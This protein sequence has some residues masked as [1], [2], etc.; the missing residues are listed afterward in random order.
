MPRTRRGTPAQQAVVRSAGAPL[1]AARAGLFT[2]VSL[3]L[4]VA[5]HHLLTG[6]AVSWPRV[7]AAAGLL[8][9]AAVPG[10]RRRRSLTTVTAACLVA[11]TGLHEILSGLHVTHG[12][13]VA[14]PAAAE[15]VHGHRP[16]VLAADGGPAAGHDAWHVRL[17]HS[18]AMTAAHVLVALVIAVVMHRAD[19][20]CWSVSSGGAGVAALVVAAMGRMFSA[21]AWTSARCRPEPAPRP[22]MRW[23]RSP[24][25]SSLL[26][27]V[28][29]RR[30][31]PRGFGIA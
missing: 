4:G 23:E 19:A 16:A 6:Q 24:P 2:L 13:H 3:A 1:A 28:V 15:A 8:F 10:A 12:L 9:A 5:S 29:V 31:P 22:G 25:K 7:G 26:A 21:W 11:Q 20:V 14:H 18:V 17:Q 27:D 30:G